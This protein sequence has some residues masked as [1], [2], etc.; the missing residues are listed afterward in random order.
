[1]L[2]LEARLHL[3]WCA[4]FAHHKPIH[5]ATTPHLTSTSLLRNI[6]AGYQGC[7]SERHV[8]HVVWMFAAAS[9]LFLAR[10]IDLC[11]SHRPSRWRVWCGQ[12]CGWAATRTHSWGPAAVT[13]LW[14]RA[15]PCWRVLRLARTRKLL[16]AWMALHQNSSPPCL[17][18][19]PSTLQRRCR[20]SAVVLPHAYRT[21]RHICCFTITSVKAASGKG[22]F[23][24]EALP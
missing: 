19:P 2:P 10:C 16:L 15:A 3:A 14:R 11:C 18:V 8:H 20:W 5:S 21:A 13:W 1:M 12:H 9:L 4:A 7:K 6:A 23:G 22:K 24:A 17:Q